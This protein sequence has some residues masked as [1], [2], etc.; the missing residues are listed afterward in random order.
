MI[1]VATSMRI[2]LAGYITSKNILINAK[3]FHLKDW[4]EETP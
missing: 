1:N 2:S 4:L 3:Y